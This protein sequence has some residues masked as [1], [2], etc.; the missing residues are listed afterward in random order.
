MRAGSRFFKKI[1]FVPN[2]FSSPEFARRYSWSDKVEL[3]KKI[4]PTS[5]SNI[6]QSHFKKVLNYVDD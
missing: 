1:S 6:W 2:L 3:V 5:Q 4:C